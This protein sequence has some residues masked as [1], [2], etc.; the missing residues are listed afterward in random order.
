MKLPKQWTFSVNYILDSL[1]CRLYRLAALSSTV[2]LA[3]ESIIYLYTESYVKMV[4]DLS[5]PVGEWKHIE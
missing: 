1:H 4:G 5:V 2:D 3:R